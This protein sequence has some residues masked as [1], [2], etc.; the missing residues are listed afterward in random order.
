MDG[1]PIRPTK[2]HVNVLQV[3]TYDRGGGA[4][5]IATRLLQACKERGFGATMAVGTRLTRDEAVRSIPREMPNH[6][7]YRFWAAAG[8]R[9][10]RFAG[11]VK[12]ARWLRLQF[13]RI[14]QPARWLARLRGLEDFHHPGTWRVL[15]LFDERPDV[16]HCHN[17]H[18]FYDWNLMRAGYFDLRALPWLCRQVPVVLTLHDAWLLSGH[19]RTSFDC[20]RWRTGC[21][22]CPDLSIYPAI[23]RDATARNWNRKRAILQSAGSTLPRRRNGSWTRCSSPCSRRRSSRRG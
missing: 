15:E 23:A 5:A 20:P 2:T 1:L 6:A 21:G 19:W 18:G 9:C 4:E 13:L 11:K 16:V 22:E 3:S 17:L 14:A 8:A 7:W 12:G 10:E